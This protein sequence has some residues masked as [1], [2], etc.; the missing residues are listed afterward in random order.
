MHVLIVSCTTAP[1]DK[2]RKS[3]SNFENQKWG[4][5]MHPVGQNQ[6]MSKSSDKS[7]AWVSSGD[8]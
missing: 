4:L 5:S 7:M 8:Y 3:I 1:G 2:P 6:L